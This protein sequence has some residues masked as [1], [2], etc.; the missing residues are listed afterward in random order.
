MYRNALD[1]RVLES[2]I[3][4]MGLMTEWKAF[5]AYA[6]VWLGMPVEAMPFYSASAS[7]RR[8][9]ARINR[10]VMDVG[11][12]GHNRNNRFYGSRTFLV[13]K[14]GAFSQRFSDLIRHTMIF[15]LDSLRFTPS[16]IVNGIKQAIKGVG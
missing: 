12:M 2:R 15:P 11:N 3:R 7:W 9:A 13:R 10:F 1:L 8:K 5:G 4:K 6:V 16:I 14:I